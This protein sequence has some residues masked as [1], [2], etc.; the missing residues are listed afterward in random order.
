MPASGSTTANDN[1]NGSQVSTASQDQVPQVAALKLPAFWPSDPELWFT[2]I[3]AQFET[4]R[5]TQESTKYAHLVGSLNPES[6]AVVR[7][8]LLAPP[9]TDRYTNLKT[10]LIERSTSSQ[11]AR[12]RQLLT[13]EELDD[14]KPSQLLRR[15]RQLVGTNTSLISES[16]LKQLFVPRLPTHVQVILTAND[17][18]SLDQMADMADKVMDVIGPQTVASV[19]ATDEVSDLKKEI[20]ELKQL[21]RGRSNDKQHANQRS[22]SKTP[23]SRSPSRSD[24]CWYHKKYAEKAQKCREPCNFRSGNANGS[25]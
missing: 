1:G 11:Q 5:V 14:R 25:H 19:A 2:Q 10:K 3:E 15:M 21:L 6:A 23:A 16:L 13:A 4:G 8:I 17:S 9:A 24:I 22:R 7:D 18:L 12:L 20:N